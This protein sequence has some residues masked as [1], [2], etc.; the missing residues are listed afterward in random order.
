MQQIAL[1]EEQR[2]GAT[3]RAAA[4]H[5]HEDTAASGGS[6]HDPACYHGCAD[7]RESARHPPLHHL[8][9]A[10]RHT[11]TATG[12]AV[13]ISERGAYMYTAFRAAAADCRQHD[14]W[15]MTILEQVRGLR[16]QWFHH[17]REL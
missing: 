2:R 9:T 1:R 7:D 5:G 8:A 11:V 16:P 4:E 6:G 12:C 17:F 13:V 14:C 3:G 10:V 15:S